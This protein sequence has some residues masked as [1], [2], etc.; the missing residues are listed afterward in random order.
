MKTYLNKI[1]PTLL[2]KMYQLFLYYYM[3]ILKYI[4]L[5]FSTGFLA[6][7]SYTSG[8][9]SGSFATETFSFPAW[10]PSDDLSNVYPDL[11]GWKV[12]IHSANYHSY[13]KYG[14][15]IK[16]IQLQVRK[17]QPLSITAIPITQK[18]DSEFVFFK[19]AG[20]VY[21]YSSNGLSWEG[22][23]SAFLMQRCFKSRLETQ[24]S[25]E[26][27]SDFIAG[28]NWKKLNESILEKDE[29]PWFWD[30]SLILTN[31]SYKNFKSTYMNA[32][33]LCEI[34]VSVFGGRNKI[35]SSYIPENQ[36]IY[37]KGIFKIP[38]NADILFYCNDGLGLLVNYESVKKYSA[39]KIY[40]P[41]FIEEL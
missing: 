16:V 8:T 1:F 40:M 29:N 12:E 28:F 32:T 10:P 4:I 11:K 6:A 37:D 5:L 20:V 2:S 23:Y 34:E 19:P 9:D 36:K 35:L 24:K 27:I 39:Q 17:N 21:P 15:S 33:G 13:V 25:S 18:N 38:K 41:I 3:K 31:I 7:C 14:N 30:D 22:G 26:E